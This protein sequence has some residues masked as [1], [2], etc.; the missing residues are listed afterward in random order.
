[1]ERQILIS[2]K[3]TPSTVLG[4]FRIG[5]SLLFVLS[6]LIR[7]H[8]FSTP[9]SQKVVSWSS[10]SS[11]FREP[12]NLLLPRGGPGIFPPQEEMVLVVVTL[13]GSRRRLFSI[14]F[15]LQFYRGKKGHTPRSK[16][17]GRDFHKFFGP[18]QSASSFMFDRATIPLRISSYS[19]RIPLSR[20]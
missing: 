18:L 2:E 15:L 16:H 1:M 10:P 13:L 12:G 17:R 8:P 3:V 14:A 19:E 6:L 4:F 7:A 20:Y 11:F 9:L 5:S